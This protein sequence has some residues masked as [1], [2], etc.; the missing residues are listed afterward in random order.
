MK[1]GIACFPSKP[2]QDKANRLRKRYD[3]HYSKIPPHI[4]LKPPYTVEESEWKVKRNHIR[5]IA[6]HTPPFPVTAYKVDTF[7]PKENKIFFKIKQHETLQ[8][9]YEA[10]NED[11]SQKEKAEFT[12]HITIGQDLQDDEHF[13]VLGRLNMKDIHYEETIDRIHWLYQLEDG[14]WTVYE[15]FLLG[16]EE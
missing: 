6:A 1:Y 15:T 11:K 9:L 12:P 7:H 8:S 5:T 16:K 4:T 10:L 2:L 13:D 3:T 14:T